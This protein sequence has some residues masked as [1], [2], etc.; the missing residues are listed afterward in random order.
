MSM[1]VL[2]ILYLTFGSKLSSYFF[3][4]WHSLFLLSLGLVYLLCHSAFTHAFL[5]NGMLFPL[6]STLY[7]Q[8]SVDVLLPKERFLGLPG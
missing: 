2:S 6:L 7:L 3:S 5:L 4:I 1:E 8:M